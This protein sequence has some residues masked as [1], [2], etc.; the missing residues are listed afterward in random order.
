MVVFLFNPLYAELNPIFHLL[1]L[2][3]AHHILHVSRI[4]VNTL[5][6]IFLLLCLCILIACLCIFIVPA[7]TLRL[8]RLSIFR[9]F[10]SVV[11]QIP[12]SKDGAQPAL[13][14]KIFGFLYI[15]YFVSFCVLFVCK[16]VLYCCHLLA[17]Q[18]QFN[19]YTIPYHKSGSPNSSS[20][21][22]TV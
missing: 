6:Y 14:Q 19:K 5:I 12:T 16:C 4:R 11:R 17:T 8:P 22:H 15:V 1:E 3:R 18:F 7:G 21:R 2:L 10:S 9:A 13:F 20:L